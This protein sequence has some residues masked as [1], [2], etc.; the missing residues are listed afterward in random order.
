MK[1]ILYSILIGTGSLTLIEVDEFLEP[2]SILTITQSTI[3]RL[4]QVKTNTCYAVIDGDPAIKIDLYMK[5][6]V[7]E[8]EVE[9]LENVR[10]AGDL[11]LNSPPEIH[12]EL[13][14]AFKYHQIAL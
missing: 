8:E 1:S 13:I 3:E 12:K 14:R 6:N 7:I 11:H 5:T 4:D 9:L 10:S 2:I